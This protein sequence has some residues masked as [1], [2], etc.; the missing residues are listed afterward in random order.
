MHRFAC[1]AGVAQVHGVGLPG[2]CVDTLCADL[3]RCSKFGWPALF[4]QRFP[5]SSTSLRTLAP[6][7][8]KHVDSK[9]VPVGEAAQA[10]R[11]L[12]ELPTA[13]LSTIAQEA[14][15]MLYWVPTPLTT[16]E[17]LSA[18]DPMGTFPNTTHCCMYMNVLIPILLLQS[19]PARL[20]S[21]GLLSG[22]SVLAF[23]IYTNVGMSREEATGE[24]KAVD[25]QDYNKFKDDA[26]FLPWAEW[27]ELQ[28]ELEKQGES[29]PEN[30]LPDTQDD[31][32]V[33]QMT[34]VLQ[35][36]VEVLKKHGNRKTLS[37]EGGQ[38]IH[39]F[40]QWMFDLIPRRSIYGRKA[41]PE[42]KDQD[43]RWIEDQDIV[44]HTKKRR[45]KSS[46]TRK[47]RKVND[48]RVKIE[49]R[50][51]CMY[52]N[53]FSMPE[54]SLEL[55]ERDLKA[56]ANVRATDATTVVAGVLLFHHLVK[57]MNETPWGAWFFF[58]A[59]DGQVAYLDVAQSTLL[60]SVEEV[61]LHLGCELD[62]NV[63]YAFIKDGFL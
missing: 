25:F 41:G 48:M 40:M 9:M 24:V 3:E 61:Q 62:P 50:A 33:P 35:A 27:N 49:G 60:Q 20:K 13:A 5:Y 11:S 38:W 14:A 17:W 2:T 16:K 36:C 15:S 54:S 39:V 52:S 12:L 43:L 63:F 21:L 28:M 8:G 44:V 32:K 30:L 1:K 26:K 51:D 42:F 34:S 23:H 53:I 59:R 6:I 55:L 22:S 37:L 29:V 18:K 58:F 31:R 7:F 57:D 56:Q 4:R 19:G 10:V 47:R 46:G 45:K